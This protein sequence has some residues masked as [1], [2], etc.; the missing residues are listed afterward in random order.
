MKATRDSA[1][2]GEKPP[3]P[4]ATGKRAEEQADEEVQEQA[5]KERKDARGYQ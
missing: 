2:P 3:T 5:A 4:A 1:G